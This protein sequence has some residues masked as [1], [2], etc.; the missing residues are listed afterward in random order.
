MILGIF[1]IDLRLKIGM[2]LRDK[3]L[4]ILNAFITLTLKQVSWK[5]KPFLKK[6]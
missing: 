2:F 1:K 3:S 4:E 6:Q 5:T